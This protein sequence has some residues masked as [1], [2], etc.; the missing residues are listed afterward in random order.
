MIKIPFGLKSAFIIN[1]MIY[2]DQLHEF[3]RPYEEQHCGK[4][5]KIWFVPLVHCKQKQQ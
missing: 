5:L 3:P 4:V 2:F 1:K